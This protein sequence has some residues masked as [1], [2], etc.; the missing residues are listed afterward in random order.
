VSTLKKFVRILDGFSVHDYSISV[1]W[2]VA[3]IWIDNREFPITEKE[4]DAVLGTRDLLSGLRQIVGEQ[5]IVYAALDKCSPQYGMNWLNQRRVRGLLA[6]MKGFTSAERVEFINNHRLLATCIERNSRWR[7]AFLSLLDELKL[8]SSELS[9]TLGFKGEFEFSPYQLLCINSQREHWARSSILARPNDSILRYVS[10]AF[11]VDSHY[12]KYAAWS[13]FKLPNKRKRANDAF[14]RTSSRLGAA[15]VSS[16]FELSVRS[17]VE[18]Y[19]RTSE[20]LEREETQE[21][22]VSFHICKNSLVRGFFYDIYRE[23]GYNLPLERTPRVLER[24]LESF[25]ICE[26]FRPFVSGWVSHGM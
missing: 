21:A 10:S 24:I 8:S 11:G 23:L 12:Y 15:P 3:K 16:L 9:A 7:L 6:I 4:E 20:W 26:V 19:T 2:I 17:L 5:F 25:A 18:N 1:Q 14:V 13:G 22:T